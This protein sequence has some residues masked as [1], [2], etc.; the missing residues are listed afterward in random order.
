MARPDVGVLLTGVG[1]RYDIVSAFFSE[2]FGQAFKAFGDTQG[3]DETAREGDFH[4]DRA[5]LRFL[6]G[7]VAI[8]AVLKGLD[9]EEESALKDEIRNGAATAF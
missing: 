1:K 3:H 5:I 9:E 4:S 2:E 8:A 6:K 7:G